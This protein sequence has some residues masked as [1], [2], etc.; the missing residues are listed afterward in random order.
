MQQIFTQV[1]SIINEYVPELYRYELFKDTDILSIIDDYRPNILTG[2]QKYKNLKFLHIKYPIDYSQY[3]TYKCENL[4]EEEEL[5]TINMM[6]EE[7][8]QKLD[9]MRKLIELRETYC[10]ELSQ[11]YSLNSN[12]AMMTYE[13]NFHCDN[14]LIRNEL[15][16]QRYVINLLNQCP[17][18][19]DLKYGICNNFV[20]SSKQF[21]EKFIKIMNLGYDQMIEDY[22]E[23]L[24]YLCENPDQPIDVHKVDQYVTYLESYPKRKIITEYYDD[25]LSP[26]SKLPINKLILEG[27]NGS[28]EPLKNV[29]LKELIINRYDKMNL[30]NIKICR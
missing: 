23:Y 1:G 18:I 11:I 7:R 3:P 21:L 30:K 6:R 5:Q 20:L 14:N 2:L 17:W 26:L 13:Y 19:N 27:F 24:V 12:L 8:L 28:L 22:N 15:N 29:P 25:D 4:S 9:M 10:I 16:A